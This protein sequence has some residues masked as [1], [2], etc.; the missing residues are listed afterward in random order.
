MFGYVRYDMPY[1][2]V[3]DLHLYRAVYCG[4]CKGIGRVC[5]QRARLA[6]TYDV[7]FLSAILHNIAGIDFEIEKQGC[8]EHWVK[9]QPI[10]KTDPLTEELGAVNTALAY[11]KLSDDIRDGG[12]GK[13]KRLFLKKGF[14]R[15]REKYPD[16]VAIFEGYMAEQQAAEV[17]GASPDSAAEPSAQMMKRLTDRLLRDKATE[18]TGEMFWYLGKWIYLI[19]ALDDYDRDVPKGQFNP[20]FESYGAADRGTLMAEHGEEV[21]FLFDTLFYGMRE[22]LAKVVFPFNRDLVDNVI[23][24]GIPSETERVLAGKPKGKEK[25]NL[26]GAI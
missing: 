7:A 5:G 13:F 23:L 12:K 26:N 4:L 24:R 11:Y 22:Q 15:A 6:L 20:F 21:R 8:F 3:K 2:F 17:K 19:D 16:L 9:K 14:R 1:L 10:A 18:A 25:L